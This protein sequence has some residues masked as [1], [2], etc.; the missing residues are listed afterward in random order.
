MYFYFSDDVNFMY[1]VKGDLITAEDGLEYIKLN[2]FQ[3]LHTN[4]GIGSMKLYATNLV[5]RNPLLS[6]YSITFLM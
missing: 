6:K 1:V 3:Y 2:K 5:E 4:R